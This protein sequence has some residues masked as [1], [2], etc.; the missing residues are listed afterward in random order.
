MNR[1]VCIRCLSMLMKENSGFPLTK[2][3]LPINS[4]KENVGLNFLLTNRPFRSLCGSGHFRSLH[5]LNLYD[6]MSAREFIC[7]LPPHERKLL[8]KEVLVLEEERVLI[9][10]PDPP[11]SPTSAQ[12]KM[13]A[14]HSA[15][16]FI[17]FGFLDNLLMIVA[18]EYI[19]AYL[20]V[21]LGIT[22]MA[23]AGLGNLISD[24]AGIGSASYVENIAARAGV[25][26][27][28]L[29]P[30]QF[31]MKKTQRYSTLGKAV[32]VALG[33]FLGMFPLLFFHSKEEDETE[34]K[35][36]KKK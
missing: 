5:N 24:V 34:K 22:T 3:I 21:A 26:A 4:S 8:I 20:G 14:I 19:D 31:T 6:K 29:T 23:A 28:P 7:R 18:G 2:L 1:T 27:P 9:E 30:Q 15:I 36:M 16:P 25:R 13:V 11:V 12:L 17:G 33:C 10:G 35:G 32:G